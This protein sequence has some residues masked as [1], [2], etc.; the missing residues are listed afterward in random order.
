[1]TDLTIAEVL[2]PGFW[3]ETPE[4]PLRVRAGGARH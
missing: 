1:M 3:Q 4:L 2:P